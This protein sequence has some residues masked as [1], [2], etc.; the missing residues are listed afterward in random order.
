M[1]VKDKIVG[2]AGLG[3]MGRPMAENILKAGFKLNVYNRTCA[4]TEDLTR[5]GATAFKTPCELAQNSDIVIVMVTGAPELEEVISRDDGI[6]SGLSDGK[7]V[8]NMSTVSPEATRIAAEMVE[9]RQANFIDAPVSG[10]KVPAEQGTLVVLAGGD[11]ELID[12]H[13]E[14]L[15]CMGKKVIRCGDIGSGTD[16]KLLVNMLL[17]NMMASFCESI[18]FGQKHGLDY[19]TLLETISAGALNSPLYSLKGEKI[20]A[21]DFEKHFSIDLLFKDLNLALT[22]SDR[23]GIPLG[24]TSACR[25]VFSGAVGMDLGDQDMCAL[26]K[27]YRRLAEKK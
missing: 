9:S 7:T 5:Q 17:G 25:E 15:L 21:G 10:S 27:F 11:S 16:M 19:D 2:F 23:Q 12:D 22:E 20:K 3:V 6:A 18:V 8:I 14:L 26:I 13:Q 1:S 24:V 4:R